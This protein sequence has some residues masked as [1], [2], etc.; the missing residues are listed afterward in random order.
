MLEREFNII[1]DPEFTK[2]NQ[3]FQATIMKLKRHRFVEV[4][5]HSPVSRKIQCLYDYYNPDPRNLQQFVWFNLMYHLIRCRR[6]NPTLQQKET[7]AIQA[8]AN[9]QIMYV[10]SE[11]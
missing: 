3:V 2:S 9:R 10:S 5:H 1:A 7:F 8:G 4:E 11:R 6:G